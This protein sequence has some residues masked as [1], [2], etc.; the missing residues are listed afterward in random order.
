MSKAKAKA[1]AR[2]WTPEQRKK[3]QATMAAKFSK[4]PEL[5]GE[6][7]VTSIPLEAIPE[8]DERPARRALP[9]NG[10]RRAPETLR[11]ELALEGIRALHS[12]LRLLG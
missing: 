10:Q 5:P 8:R 1:S 7:L 6:A 9:K 3:F 12:I 4:I 2:K 11:L